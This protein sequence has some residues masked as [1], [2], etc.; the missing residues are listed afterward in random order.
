MTGRGRKLCDMKACKYVRE[1]LL[2]EEL[3]CTVDKASNAAGRGQNINN[4]IHSSD[5]H[6]SSLKFPQPKYECLHQKLLTLP[7]GY[8]NPCANFYQKNRGNSIGKVSPVCYIISV[9]FGKISIFH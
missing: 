8:H 2:D 1:E 9:M 7:I 6:V 4:V 5:Y 3:G